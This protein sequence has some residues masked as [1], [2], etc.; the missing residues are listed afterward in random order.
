MTEDLCPA[1][2]RLKPLGRPDV[3]KL[4]V[5]GDVTARH[6]KLN[7]VVDEVDEHLK[8]ATRVTVDALEELM[9]VAN[10]SR[11]VDRPFEYHTFG[12]GDLLVDQETLLDDPAE[13]KVVL[14]DT[15]RA[16]VE[17]G[18]VHQVVQEDLGHV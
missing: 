17:L 4:D 16:V 3:H 13:V 2:K 10:V 1:R 14:D 12:R 6:R 8:V 15:E 18:E 7:G 5:N 11:V 9:G